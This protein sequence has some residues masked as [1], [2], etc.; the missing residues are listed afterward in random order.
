MKWA[1]GNDLNIPSHYNHINYLEVAYNYIKLKLS[2]YVKNADC[3]INRTT[4]DSFVQFPQPRLF[5]Y[6]TNNHSNGLGQ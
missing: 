3:E 4:L 5:P 2:L 6:E 1:S